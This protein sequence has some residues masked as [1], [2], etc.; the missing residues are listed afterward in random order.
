MRQVVV[1][2]NNIPEVGPLFAPEVEQQCRPFAAGFEGRL[3]TV[4]LVT[5]CNSSSS[6]SSLRVD[7]Q[8]VRKREEFIGLLSKAGLIFC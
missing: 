6:S 4:Y 1:A 8:I 7:M 5:Y 2:I 3:L